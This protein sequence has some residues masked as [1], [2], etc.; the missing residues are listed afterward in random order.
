MDTVTPVS[1]ED[2]ADNLHSA[3]INLLRRVR[4]VD[5]A[6]G[7]NAARL[8]TLSYLVFAGPAT[9]GELARS[10]QV[11]PASISQLVTGM[12]RDGLAERVEDPSDRRVTLVCATKKGE[13]I[14]RE[15][16]RARVAVLTNMLSRLSADEVDALVK[17][18]NI[19][20]S[21]LRA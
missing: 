13:K 6:T 2:V 21:A 9:V 19:I 16:R 15:G 8:S 7:L 1:T 20:E 11:T 12:Q 14:M 10:E 4:D 18:T 5:A 17:A 3:A